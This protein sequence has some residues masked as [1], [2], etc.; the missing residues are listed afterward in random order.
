[1]SQ[2]AIDTSGWREPQDE[3]GKRTW[4][5]AQAIRYAAHRTMWDREGPVSREEMDRRQAFLADLVRL[6]REHMEH[7]DQTI[8]QLVKNLSD[9]ARANPHTFYARKP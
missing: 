8:D 6:C 4:A 1:M 9:I 2:N 7:A 5:L 3:L